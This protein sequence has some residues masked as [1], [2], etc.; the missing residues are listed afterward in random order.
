MVDKPTFQNNIA[1]SLVTLCS[2]YI[3]YEQYITN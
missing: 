2:E 3:N 1:Q